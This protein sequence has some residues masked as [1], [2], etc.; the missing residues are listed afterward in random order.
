MTFDLAGARRAAQEGRLEAWVHAYLRGP[1]RNA[2]FADGPLLE[3]RRW[4]GPV[5]LPLAAPERVCGPDPDL[6][7]PVPEAAWRR[8]LDHFAASFVRLEDFPPLI[9]EFD[10]ARLAIHDGNHRHGAFEQ[11]G[12]AS[13]WC[14]L[15]YPDDARY[16]LHESRAFALPSD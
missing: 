3:P 8:T 7:Y 16:R 2:A 9:V 14:V 12:L 13:C 15:W 6:P 10:P 11:L 5:E 1:A 4:R